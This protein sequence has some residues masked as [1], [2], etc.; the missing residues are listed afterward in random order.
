M[1]TTFLGLTRLLIFT[2]YLLIFADQCFAFA[3]THIPQST[4]GILVTDEVEMPLTLKTNDNSAW[5]EP[6]LGL[7]SNVIILVLMVF[8]VLLTLLSFFVFRLYNLNHLKTQNYAAKV[9]ELEIEVQANVALTSL[10]NNIFESSKHGIIAFASIKNDQNEIIDFKYQMINHVAA[11]MIGFDM[12]KCMDNSMLTLLPGNKESGLFDAYKN[13]VLTAEP[14]QTILHYDHDCIDKWFSISAVKNQDGFIV[15]FSD[16]SDLKENER[17]MVKKQIE[18]EDANHELEQFTYIAS[19]DLQEPLRKIRAFGDRLEAGY[20]NVLDE[21][22]KDFINR[23]RNASA[24]MQTLIDDLLKFSRATRGL[25]TMTS[26]DLNK[27]LEDVQDVLFEPIKESNAVINVAA[28]GSI[29][30][31]ESQ[32]VQ[33]F[34]NILSNALKYKKKD[35]TPHISI[36]STSRIVNMNNTDISFCEISVTDNGIGFD[37]TYKEKIFEI[38]QRLHGRNEYKGTGIGLAICA[39]IITNHQGRIFAESELDKG[40]T[41]FIQLPQ[42]RIE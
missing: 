32:M 12:E 37:N 30:A 8:V 40:T 6:I 39:K 5:F 41:F 33:L 9:A 22:G 36:E 4:S 16:V 21:K 19:H 25:L 10:L 29:E 26:V 38:F 18:L 31:N 17:L 7:Q 27:V 24:R 11:K 13:T 14:F 1:K 28:L 15:T 34:Q 35:I 23:M 20:G 2:S 42:E 3:P